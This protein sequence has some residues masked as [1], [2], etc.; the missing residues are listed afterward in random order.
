MVVSVRNEQRAAP[1][2]VARIAR[3]A[4]CAVRRLT[5][6]AEGTLAITFIDPRRM[7]ALNRRFLAHDRTTDVLSFRYEGELIV[8]DILVSPATARRY[9][10]AHGLPYQ[11]ELARYVVHGLLHWVGYHDA[12]AKDRRRIRRLEDRLLS[13]CA[14]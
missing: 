5:I 2:N 3:L 1:V 12:T 13:H 4:R 6:R 11:E 7:R 14:T 8:G 10:S 9:A